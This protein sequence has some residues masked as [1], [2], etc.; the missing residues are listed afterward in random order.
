MNNINVL[1]DYYGLLMHKINNFDKRTAAI[2][3]AKKCYH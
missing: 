3:K 2:E 1:G